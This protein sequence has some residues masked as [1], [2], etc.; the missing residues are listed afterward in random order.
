MQMAVLTIAVLPVAVY[1]Q[2]PH[3]AFE[4]ELKAGVNIGGTVPTP[5]PEEIR[6]IESFSPNF[7]GSI[8]GTVTYRFGS[9]RRWGAETGL[10]IESKSMSTGAKVKNYSTEI[11]DGVSSVKGYWT[12]YVKTDF[13]CTL[14][15]VPL[16]ADLYFGKRWKTKAGLYASYAIDKDF[17]GQ[18]S[19]GYLRE[20]TPVGQKL[21]FTEGDSAQYDFTSDMR[22]FQYGLVAGASWMVYNH[23]LLDAEVSWAI[24]GL[25]P[26]DFRTITFGMHPLFCNVGFGYRF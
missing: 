3:G 1:A 19:D 23:L 7:N 25:F 12:G 13:G 22:N 5:F 8:E 24:N 6:S 9:E 4:Y 18:V 14:L 17:S 11:I 2:E 15:T 10:R 16:T 20:G 26:K 21:E